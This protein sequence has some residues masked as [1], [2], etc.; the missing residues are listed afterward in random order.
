MDMDMVLPEE[1]DYYYTLQREQKKLAELHR[2][3][4][5]QQW[6]APR[7]ISPGSNYALPDLL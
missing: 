4:E 7:N 1:T 5:F 6:L 3:C 2:A